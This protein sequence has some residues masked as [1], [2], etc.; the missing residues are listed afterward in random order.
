MVCKVRPNLASLLGSIAR[1][2]HSPGLDHRHCR[3]ACLPSLWSTEP[4]LALEPRIPV[5]RLAYNATHDRV[6]SPP[7]H[8]QLVVQENYQLD[9]DSRRGRPWSVLHCYRH[10]ARR[11]WS[12]VSGQRSV[13]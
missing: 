9:G 13:E 4:N 10:S 3:L 5:L 12:K 8:R 6:C 2:A 1:L 11:Q 7:C